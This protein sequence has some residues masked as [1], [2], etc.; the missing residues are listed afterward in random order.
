[1][2]TLSALIGQPLTIDKAVGYMTIEHPEYGRRR[3]NDDGHGF[4]SFGVGSDSA[5]LAPS[6]MPK[7]TIV[8]VP[9]TQE[10]CE[11]DANESL[12]WLARQGH[13]ASMEECRARGLEF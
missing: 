13:S 7:W 6:E 12:V 1:M 3:L 5:L 10:E 2:T 9:K 11:A 8:A 4:W